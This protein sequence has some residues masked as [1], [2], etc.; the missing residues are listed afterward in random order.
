M[1]PGLQM[2]MPASSKGAHK[3]T[4]GLIHPLFDPL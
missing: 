2:T 4:D 3:M 1:I